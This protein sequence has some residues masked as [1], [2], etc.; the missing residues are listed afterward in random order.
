MYVQPD[1]RQ[2]PRRYDGQLNN[3]Q[4]DCRTDRAECT[5]HA[6]RKN[7]PRLRDGKIY[8][9]KSGEYQKSHGKKEPCQSEK[10][11]FGG[12]TEELV[13]IG[14][15]IFLYLEGEKTRDNLLLIAA[16]GYLL[17]N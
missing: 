2:I 15:M 4:N 3:F 6:E 10:H 8:R 1:G 12:S 7:K 14:L 9:F 13:I 17:L 11:K 16:L 5:D